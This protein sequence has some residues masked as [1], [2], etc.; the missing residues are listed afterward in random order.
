MSITKSETGSLLGIGL[1]T[2][3]EAGRLTGV[4]ATQI[5]RWLA[6]YQFRDRGKAQLADPL[7]QPQVER[8]G[9][10]VELGFRDL[11]EI[12][13]VAA[14]R[15]AGVSLQAIRRAIAIARKIIDNPYPLS[16][17]K[18]RT[19]GRTIFLQVQEEAHEPAVIDLLKGQY[20][21]RRIIEPSFRDLDLEDGI[22]SR[23]WPLSHRRSVV[24]DPERNFGQPI[25]AKDGVPTFALA[26][27]VMAEGSIKKAAK[28]FEVSEKSVRDA[29][30]FERRLAA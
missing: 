6:G 7:W 9:R 2:A 20:A 19:D 24:L 27:A 18:F 23:W 17:A 10:E 14:F 22:A 11:I 13:L 4:P 12:K 5:R 16:T 25:V 28:A 8:I 30:E 29:V 21:F 3:S 26:Q 15:K 1:Y